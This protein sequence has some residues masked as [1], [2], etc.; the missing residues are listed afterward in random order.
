MVGDEGGVGVVVVVFVL[1]DV[2]FF[3]LIVF[4]CVDGGVAV[5]QG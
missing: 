5:A 1:E 2:G 3:V 4:F